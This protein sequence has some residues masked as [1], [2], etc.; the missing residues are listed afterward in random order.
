MLYVAFGQHL[1]DYIIFIMLMDDKM[2]NNFI[3]DDV[4]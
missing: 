1:A 2:S 3:T 4:L